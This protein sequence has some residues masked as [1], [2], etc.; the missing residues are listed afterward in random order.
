MKKIKKIVDILFVVLFSGGILLISAVYIRGLLI[1]EAL[2]NQDYYAYIQYFFLLGIAPLVLVY[3]LYKIGIY[4][5]QRR[6]N[7]GF[8]KNA[9]TTIGFYLFLTTIALNAAFIFYLQ[10]LQ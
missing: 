2:R 4:L 8:Q 6:E 5:I 3:I 9:I 1:E 10:V 7:H